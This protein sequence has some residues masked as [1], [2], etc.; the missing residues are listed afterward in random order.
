MTVGVVPDLFG[1]LCI[2]HSRGISPKQLFNLK[3]P[4]MISTWIPCILFSSYD[5]IDRDLLLGFSSTWQVTHHLLIRMMNWSDS[6]YPKNLI[7]AEWMI[8]LQWDGFQARLMEGLA[9]PD[10][11]R[12]QYFIDI[13]PWHSQN[14][15]LTL[16]WHLH[17]LVRKISESCVS[18]CHIVR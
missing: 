12:N 7:D 14:N 9:P 8:S 11:H 5:G 18:N 13:F 10:P 3:W 16:P 15:N 4:G 2:R 6:Q 1:T 17:L